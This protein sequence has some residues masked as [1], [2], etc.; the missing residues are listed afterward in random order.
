MAISHRWAFRASLR[1][2]AFD[3]SGTRKA[4][5]RLNAAV[6]EIERVARADPALAA[7]GAVL[8][9]EKLSPAVNQIDSSSGTLGNATAGVVEKMLPLITA[10]DLRLGRHTDSNCT[11]DQQVAPMMMNGSPICWHV[12]QFGVGAHSAIHKLVDA[13]G[14]Q[15]VVSP[16]LG[17]RQAFRSQ[18]SEGAVG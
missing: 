3:W 17:R 14:D 16:A 13:V 12:A 10:A 9:L 4:I 7:E 2:N 15:R 6:G 11:H 8:L 18:G 5:E 1:R